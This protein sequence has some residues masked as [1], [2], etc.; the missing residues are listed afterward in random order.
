MNLG[1]YT[2][3]NDPLPKLFKIKTINVEEKQFEY[4]DSI[5][6]L[7]KDELKVDKMDSE[8]VYAL[9]LTYGLVPRGILLVSMGNN[10]THIANMRGLGIGLLLTGAEQFM[11]FHNHPG[12]NKKPSEADYE[13]TKRYEELGRVLGIDFIKHIMIAG[14]YYESC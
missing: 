10:E 14:D 8:F 13:M 5:V 4:T 1:V 2:I 7:L 9:S 3:I 11:V 12:K 6:E